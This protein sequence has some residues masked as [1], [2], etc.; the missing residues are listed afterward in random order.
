MGK[1]ENMLWI[2]WESEEALFLFGEIW[3]EMVLRGGD[4]S[5]VLGSLHPERWRKSGGRHSPER[6][7]ELKH[8]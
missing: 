5:M 8:S 4:L 1:E 7:Q 2:W 3:S 6:L